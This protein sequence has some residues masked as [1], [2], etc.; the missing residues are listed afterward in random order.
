MLSLLLILHMYA[1]ISLLLKAHVLTHSRGYCGIH[2]QPWHRTGG[3]LQG[4]LCHGR[5]H[6][7]KDLPCMTDGIF[8][9]CVLS[10]LTSTLPGGTTI[11]QQVCVMFC[12]S[13]TYEFAYLS[14]LELF[15]I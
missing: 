6:P 5:W 3:H 11:L 7:G 8:H 14:L 4:S 15:V 2:F 13:G 10:D 9:F 12:T 1:G